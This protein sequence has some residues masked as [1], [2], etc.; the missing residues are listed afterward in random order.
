ML[1]E[2]LR[3]DGSDK[4]LAQLDPLRCAHAAHEYRELIRE[5]TNAD[6]AVA[7]RN[8]LIQAPA[9]RAANTAHRASPLTPW[10]YNGRRGSPTGWDEP[11]GLG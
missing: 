3:F 2:I 5:G 9:T 7:I 8:H 11:L 4:L 10:S 6:G 1:Q